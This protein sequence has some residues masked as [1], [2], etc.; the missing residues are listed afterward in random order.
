MEA[1]SFNK[2]I[3]LR[4]ALVVLSELPQ[5]LFH[6]ALNTKQWNWVVHLVPSFDYIVQ[7]NAVSARLT[8]S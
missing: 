8:A 2:E 6:S 4:K 5:N 3:K 7:A 1:F